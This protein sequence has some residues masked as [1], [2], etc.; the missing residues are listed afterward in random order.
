MTG[1]IS[2]RYAR[3]NNHLIDKIG[4]IHGDITHDHG[5]DAIVSTL[6]PDLDPSGALNQS[7]MRGAGAELD[8][9]I[10]E[11]IYK[12]RPGDVFSVPGFNLPVDNVIYTISKPWQ[13][14]LHSEDRDL[15]RCYRRPMKMAIRM[16]W[17]KI[18]FP[19]L[20]TGQKSFPAKRA[21]R[22]AMQG[23]LQRIDPFFEYIYIICN[24][25]ETFNAFHERMKQL[26]WR[27]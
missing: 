12:P 16:G 22:L 9:F 8:G 24:R 14:G 18:A 26:G 6:G 23:I 13:D 11:N 7:I 15:L 17:K 3:S 10:L 2:E 1:F 4:L 20:A 25:D 5:V 19:A 21:A 27:G